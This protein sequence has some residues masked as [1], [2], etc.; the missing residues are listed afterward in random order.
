MCFEGPKSSDR[1][2]VHYRTQPHLRLGALVQASAPRDSHGA[3]AQAMVRG[4]EVMVERLPVRV[5]DH[6]FRSDIAFIAGRPKAPVVLVF[7]NYAGKKQFDVD[8]AVFLARLGYVGVAVD[9]YGESS[10]YKAVDRNPNKDSSE[11]AVVKHWRGAFNSMNELLR[12]PAELH[13]R[14]DS[15]L[16]AAREHHSAHPTMAGGIGYCFGGVCV[17]EAVRAGLDLQGVVSF[18]G[19]LQ[20]KPI[21]I[22]GVSE[23]EEKDFDFK[24]NPVPPVS[25]RGYATWC[26]VV[27]ENGD[28]DH[29]VS[30]K[31]IAE[32]KKE[33][34]KHNVDWRFHN[35]AKTP[36][37]FALP[38]GVWAT[39][40]NE[41]ADRRSTLSMISLF[42][43]VWPEVHPDLSVRRNAAGTLLQ[44]AKF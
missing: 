41:A 31:S 29:L 3:A 17:L 10:E 15:T 30:D 27:V 11:E 24:V 42:S 23:G 26:K 28:E 36:H 12:N 22:P 34:N 9:I 14:M 44:P 38:P 40:Y 2:M 32:W 6:V 20:S 1:P 39:G 25:A 16:R 35:H 4:G 21:F 8:Q 33:F 43:E 19:L 18:H 5:G 7:P 37:G 13:R